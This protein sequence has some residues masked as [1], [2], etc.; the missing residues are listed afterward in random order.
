MGIWI[1]LHVLLLQYYID[2]SSPIVPQLL[3]SDQ[4]DIN[5]MLMLTFS[6]YSVNFFFITFMKPKIFS[7]KTSL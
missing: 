1:Y 2:K 4:F 3:C 6:N 7:L 5:E